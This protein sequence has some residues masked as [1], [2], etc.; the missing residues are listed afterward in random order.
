LKL[1]KKLVENED[2]TCF[3]YGSEVVHK[4][5]SRYPLGRSLHD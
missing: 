3:R 4:N 1:I 5:Q 2:I